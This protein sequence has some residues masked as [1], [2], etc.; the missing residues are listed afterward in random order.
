MTTVVARVRQLPLIFVGGAARSGTT[1]LRR[2]LDSH[3]NIHCGEEMKL[4]PLICDTRRTWWGYI[5]GQ[6]TKM[7]VTQEALDDA[8]AALIGV[9]LT[10]SGALD[11]CRVAE[12]TPHNVIE[13][14]LLARL[15]PCAKFVHV[16][17]DGRAV[18]AS[19]IK[20][21]WGDSLTPDKGKVWY[22]RDTTN[23]AKYWVYV[24]DLA[25]KNQDQVAPER[26]HVLRYE[27][28]ILAPEATL[29]ALFHFLGEP[30]QPHVLADNPVL[31]ADQLNKWRTELTAEQV[32]DIEREAGTV[33]RKLGYV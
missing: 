3:T 18:V 31:P 26:Y 25:Q 30:W 29:Q 7:G 23:A 8:F 1:Y 13:F 2:V 5:Q 11:K 6:A 9:Y 28:L 4:I 15:F 12:K 19:L 20:E 16:L 22:C 14:G 33:L 10:H 32:A 27:N 17:R 21:S 24:L